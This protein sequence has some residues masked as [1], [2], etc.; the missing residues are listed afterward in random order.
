MKK[1]LLSIILLGALL[2]SCGTKQAGISTTISGRFV[3]SGADS[4]FLERIADNFV[5]SETLA[6]VAIEDNGGFSFDIAIE[7][8][9]APRFYKLTFAEGSRPV[10]LVVAPGDNITL[11]AAGD[12]FLNYI[13]EG[14]EES[15]L[16]REFNRDYF[17]P[18]DRLALIAERLHTAD[19][20]SEREAYRAA[21][22]AMK[23]QV[24]FVG[25][26]LQNLAAL[27]AMRHS[28][29]EQYIPQL[30]GYGITIAHYNAVLGGI[31]ERYPDS[32]YIAYLEKQIA[33]GEALQSVLNRVE[34]ADY[35]DIE[36]EDMYRTKHR[37]ASL[38]GNVTL[39]YFWIAESAIC[40][41]INA[42]LK[43]LYER[44]HDKGFEVYHVSADA[45]EAMWIEAVRQQSHPWISV[46]GGRN[47][48]VFTL[49][50]VATLPKAYLIDRK[51]NVAV[52]P[53]DMDALEREIKRRL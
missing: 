28:V 18:C 21:Q 39:L 33:D 20:Y 15:A 37:L 1:Y 9:S 38:S 7:E 46:Y 16:I 22:E 43:E 53:L 26:H 52:A 8:Q 35:P 13:V 19:R 12:I 29:A 10:T 23:A 24:R 50:N 30:D 5:T 25:S 48:E 4:V 34:L 40:N 49:F 27:Y 51:G 41:N 47:A 42:D 11:E 2:T 45:D 3:G 36:L 17:T 32:P 14:S 31:R 6:G 44:Y